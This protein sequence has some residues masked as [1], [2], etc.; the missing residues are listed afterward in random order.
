[1]LQRWE[2]TKQFSLCRFRGKIVQKDRPFQLWHINF[3]LR[4]CRVKISNWNWWESMKIP[5]FYFICNFSDFCHRIYYSDKTFL[6]TEDLH[7][8]NWSTFNSYSW[9][10]FA[11]VTEWMQLLVVKQSSSFA[12][13]TYADDFTS[14]R[15]WIALVYLINRQLSVRPKVFGRGKREMNQWCAGRSRRSSV[16][17]ETQSSLEV[18]AGKCA[19]IKSPSLHWEGATCRTQSPSVNPPLII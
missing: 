19:D 17:C 14:L 5:H 16:L 11:V 1:M 15:C 3:I 2:A 12:A 18:K 6:Q 9:F 4:N 8:W 7:F 13:F 10:T